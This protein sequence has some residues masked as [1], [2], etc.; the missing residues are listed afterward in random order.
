MGLI[1]D[2]FHKGGPFMWPILVIAIFALAIGAER[3]Y[4]IL[5]RANIK[6][7]DKRPFPLPWNIPIRTGVCMVDVMPW[8][9]NKSDWPMRSRN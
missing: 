9:W 8:S 3:L 6:D 5:L 4:Y 2:A 7:S 1:V